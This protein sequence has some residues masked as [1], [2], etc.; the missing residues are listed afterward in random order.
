MLLTREYISALVPVVQKADQENSKSVTILKS[1]WESSMMVSNLPVRLSITILDWVPQQ[2]SHYRGVPMYL[3]ITSDV[4]LFLSFLDGL[5]AIGSWD[6][7]NV[8]VEYFSTEDNTWET[9]GDYPFA[10]RSKIASSYSDTTN[11]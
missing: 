7:D 8:V 10:T 6:P 4:Q 3:K 2:V 11:F 1:L 9:L 5:L